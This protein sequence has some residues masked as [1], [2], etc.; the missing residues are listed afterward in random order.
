MRRP[1]KIR[2][3]N[4]ASA[5]R[6]ALE[7]GAF[8][9]SAASRIIRALAGYSQEELASRLGLNVKVIR[10]LEA[11]RGNPRY[12]SLQKLA[13]AVGLRV[14]FVRPSSTIEI[15]DPEARIADERRRREADARA[16]ASGETSARVL[17][18]RNALHI[19]DVSYKLPKLA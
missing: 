13:A 2:D 19:G 4:L 9:P 6:E 8:E 15:L 12:D 5:L 1:Q 18:E 16:I 17:H 7:R 14:A 10:A 11:G 3:P